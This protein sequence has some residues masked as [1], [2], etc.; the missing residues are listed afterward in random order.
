MKIS[1]VVEQGNN[2]MKKILVRSEL[3]ARGGNKTA[4]RSAHQVS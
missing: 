2:I 4:G 3:N 1:R